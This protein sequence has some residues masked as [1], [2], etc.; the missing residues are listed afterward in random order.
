MSHNLKLKQVARE[1]RK[2]M[3]QT[4]KLLWLRLRGKQ[5]LGLQFYR[6]K[7]LLNF[8]VDFYPL[9]RKTLRFS[10]RI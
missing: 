9:G 7:V 4:E 8:I 2:N 10:P 6:Q 5:I 3:T 1:L